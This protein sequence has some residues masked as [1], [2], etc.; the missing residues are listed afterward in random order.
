[1]PSRN[2]YRLTW[3][4]LPWTWCISSRLLQQSAAAAPYLGRGASHHG[5]PS[6]LECGVAP[7]GSPAP[8]HP[9]LL[10]P[11]V[12]NRKET[13]LHPSTENWIKDLLSTVPFIRTRPSFPLSQSLPAGSFHKPIILLHQRADRVWRKGNSLTLLVGM[14]TSTAA[15]ENS[16]EIP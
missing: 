16:V 1:M 9:L 2:T 12:K 14:Q 3:I 8:A 15:M 5:R 11:Q 10:W 4:L 13:Q 6:N 7:L